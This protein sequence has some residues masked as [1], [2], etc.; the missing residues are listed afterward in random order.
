MTLHPLIETMNRSGQSKATRAR[1]AAEAGDPYP[2]LKDVTVLVE[3]A[4]CGFAI[5]ANGLGSGNSQG[6]S[7]IA[8]QGIAYHSRCSGR[9]I[10]VGDGFGQGIG[11]GLT[12]QSGELTEKGIQRRSVSEK[13][14]Y[15]FGR[16][17][18]KLAEADR[19]LRILG[20][21]LDQLASVGDGITDGGALI[22]YDGGLDLTGDT[23]YL[24]GDLPLKSL[25]PIDLECPGWRDVFTGGAGPFDTVRQLSDVRFHLPEASSVCP[26]DRFRCRVV[27]RYQRILEPDG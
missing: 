16:G 24:F 18:G 27:T 17:L 8:A 14:N 15:R 6:S 2:A 10:S 20:A 3:C 19:E 25:V 5:G 11:D 9:A 23:S 22:A 4:G 21:H 13:A 1:P 12:G 26:D 7:H